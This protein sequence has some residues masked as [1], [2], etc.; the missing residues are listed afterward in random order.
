MQALLCCDHFMIF[1]QRNGNMFTDRT[2]GADDENLHKIKL[3]DKNRDC[4]PI[5]IHGEIRIVHFNG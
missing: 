4:N 2:R 5:I 1:L 3:D